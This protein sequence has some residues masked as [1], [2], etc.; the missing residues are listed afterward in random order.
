M[1]MEKGEM[2]KA[3]RIYS[4]KVALEAV[5]LAEESVLREE[6]RERFGLGCEYPLTLQYS[7]VFYPPQV[8]KVLLITFA[9]GSLHYNSNCG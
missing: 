7:N 2:K 4:R 9:V 6:I 3:G 1:C 8:C 5:R